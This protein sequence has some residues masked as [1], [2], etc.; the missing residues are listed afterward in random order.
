M[1]TA[2]IYGLI[3]SLGDIAPLL[4]NAEPA[5][6]A[7]LYERLGLEMTYDVEAKAVSVTIR[8]ERVV[9]ARVHGRTR[10]LTPSI[11]LGAAWAAL[12]LYHARGQQCRRQSP[13]GWS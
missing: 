7:Q 3:R 1:P 12:L 10:T 4:D 11:D 13:R 9:S 8:P 2:S 5:L 6:L